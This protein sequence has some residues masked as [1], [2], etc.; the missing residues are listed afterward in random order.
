MNLFN[1]LFTLFLTLLI[2]ILRNYYPMLVFLIPL[3]ILS[4]LILSGRSDLE[5]ETTGLSL[6]VYYTVA[7]FSMYLCIRSYRNKENKTMGMSMIMLF[8]S[9]IGLSQ[10][11]QTI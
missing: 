3:F 10:T 1:L 5:Y 11:V 9:L 2:L 4:C 8:L 6:F 7:F